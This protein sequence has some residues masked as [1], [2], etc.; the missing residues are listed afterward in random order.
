MARPAQVTLARLQQAITLGLV[1]A[2]TSWA[3]AFLSL[4][5]PFWGA[6]G[7]ALISFGYVILLGLEFALLHAVHRDDP[8]PRATMRRLIGAWFGEVLTAPRVFCWRQPFRSLAVPDWLPAPDSQRSPRHGVLL[9]H[10]YFCNRGLWNPWMSRLRAAGVPYLA[11]NLEPAFASID[12][13]APQIEAAVNC[14]EAA[15]GRAPVVVAHSMGGLAARSWLA[16]F[17]GVHRVQHLVT[18]GTPHRGTWLGR[19]AFSRNAAEMRLGSPWLERLERQEALPGSMFDRHRCT[20]FY[21]HCDNI[22]FPA[23]AAT[24][25][26]ADNRHIAGSAHL[27]LAFVPEVFDEVLRLVEATDA[28]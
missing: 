6:F 8:V 14:L 18:V 25:P 26:G 20:C 11:I 5:K 4:G 27:H 24:L 28:C 1:L 15:T 22:V 2:S 19:F 17:A 10:G 3:A 12:A 23:S 13:Y 9:L 16:R 7:A 21:S